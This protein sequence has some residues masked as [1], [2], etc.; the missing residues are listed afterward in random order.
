M[1]SVTESLSGQCIIVKKN[2]GICRFYFDISLSELW[3]VTVHVKCMDTC[4]VYLWEG[5]CG[6]RGGRGVRACGDSK[7]WLTYYQ[8]STLTVPLPS[9]CFYAVHLLLFQ[10]LLLPIHHLSLHS[11]TVLFCLLTHLLLTWALLV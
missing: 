7:S 1:G 8:S 11:L 2:R 6:R 10:S 3:A 9:R 4:L 5:C